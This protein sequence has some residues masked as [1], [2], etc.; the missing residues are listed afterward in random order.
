MFIVAMMLILYKKNIKVPVVLIPVDPD[1][2]QVNPFI[3]LHEYRYVIL[4]SANIEKIRCNPNVSH[5]GL[6]DGSAS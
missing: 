2:S 4:G 1:A 6:Y 5:G 3:N